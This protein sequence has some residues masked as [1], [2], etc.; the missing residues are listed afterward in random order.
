MKIP[1][2]YSAKINIQT[3]RGTLYK[4]S[5]FHLHMSNCILYRSYPI[6][7]IVKLRI[8]SKYTHLSHIIEIIPNKTKSVFE[9]IRIL[10]QLIQIFP[11]SLCTASALIQ[12]LLFLLNFVKQLYF[13][14]WYKNFPPFKQNTPFKPQ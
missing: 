10:F 5:L 6:H 4:F 1:Y 13:R 9:L 7:K 8:Q 12:L 3:F 11:P 14:R 2:Q